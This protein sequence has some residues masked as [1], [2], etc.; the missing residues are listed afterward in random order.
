MRMPL[1]RDCIRGAI[2][3]VRGDQSHRAICLRSRSIAARMKFLTPS[4]N[5]QLRQTLMATLKAPITRNDHIRG[6]ANAPITVVE[7]G[8]FECPQCGLA[9]PIVKQL[10]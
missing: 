5:S 2:N 3:L 8:D 6:P 7:Y 4:K 9:Y 10:Q 1:L